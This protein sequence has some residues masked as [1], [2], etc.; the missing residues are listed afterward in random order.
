M[1][2]KEILP[3]CAE[4]AKTLTDGILAKKAVANDIDAT[5]ETETLRAISEKVKDATAA[6]HVLEEKTDTL[7]GIED[8]EKAAYYVRDEVLPAM[9]ALRAPCDKLETMVDDKVWP[10]P[11]Y[12]KLLFGIL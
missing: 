11:T 3:A 10:F 6:C 5:Y 8:F 4:Y 9:D 1:A 2:K 12:G 7:H